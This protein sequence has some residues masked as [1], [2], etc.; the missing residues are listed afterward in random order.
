MTT[1]SYRELSSTLEQLC[2]LVNEVI[3]DMDAEMKTLDKEIKQL[4]ETANTA[5]VLWNQA[6]YIAEE[7]VIFDDAFLRLHN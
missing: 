2:D 6:N 4:E 1:T 3:N 7:L 5:E